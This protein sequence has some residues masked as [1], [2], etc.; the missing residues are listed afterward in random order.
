VVVVDNGSDDGS[1]EWLARPT[2]HSSFGVP[3]HLIA[4]TGNRGYPAAVNQA[5]AVALADGA[6]AVLLVND[7]AV[8]GPGA[9]A[10]LARALES[11]PDVGAASAHLV[12]RDRPGLLNGAGGVVDRRRAMAAL[13]GSGEPD[14][15]QYDA[16]PAVDYPSGAAGLLAR[17]A[18]VATGPFDEAWYLYYEDADWGLRAA[19][20]GWRTVYVPE[21]RVLHLGSAGTARDPAR[22]RYYN[23]RNRL[24]FAGRHGSLRGR[25]WV[26]GATLWL[27]AKQPLRWLSAARRRDAVAV[28]G[29]V[30]D[31]LRRRYGRSARFG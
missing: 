13:R 30:A 20:A 27:L 29:A 15:G 4:N 28:V 21:A 22:R 23:V 1:A 9:V 2:V 18:L 10:A 11:S 25:C 14:A 6:T 7:D 24:R 8:F 17:R 3:V 5:L 12:Y 19:A 31:H 26:W 16:L